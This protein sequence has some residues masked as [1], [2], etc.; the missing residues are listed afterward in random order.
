MTGFPIHDIASAPK[1]SAPILGQVSQKLGFVPNLFGVMAEAPALLEAY[2]ALSALFDKSSFT[3]TERQVIL[4]AVSAENQCL[5]CV[6]AHSAI[7]AMKRVPEPAVSA[8]R[9]GRPID[10][11][12]LEALRRFVQTLVQKRGFASDEDVQVFLT[13][14]YTKGNVLEAVLGVGMKTLSNYTNHLAETPV[15]SAFQPAGAAQIG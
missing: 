15:D 14:G 4:L 6:A 13:A 12:R 11:I 5:Y 8:I 7:A 9:D 2:V 1:E 3:P 10:D